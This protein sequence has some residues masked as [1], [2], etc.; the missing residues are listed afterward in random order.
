MDCCLLIPIGSSTQ[1]TRASHWASLEK[2]MVYCNWQVTRYFAD[3]PASYTLRAFF[4]SGTS[5]SLFRPSPNNHQPTRSVGWDLRNP[6]TAN[7]LIKAVTWSF[8]LMVPPVGSANGCVLVYLL[9]AFLNLIVV[10][11]TEHERHWIVQQ[12]CENGKFETT[13]LL[14]QRHWHIRE[15]FLEIRKVPAASHRKRCWSCYCLVRIIRFGLF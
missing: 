7:A 5:R 13:H 8:A 6:Q 10:A 11:F 12:D 15:A 14:Q 2:G 3:M 4:L 9:A 1:S